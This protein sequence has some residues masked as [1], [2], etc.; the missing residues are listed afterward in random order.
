MADLALSPRLFQ[1]QQNQFPIKMTRSWEDMFAFQTYK[2]HF[3]PPSSMTTLQLEK[4]EIT[5]VFLVAFRAELLPT[6]SGRAL[7]QTYRCN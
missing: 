5:A 1:S 6:A 2:S 7:S 3:F 4:L